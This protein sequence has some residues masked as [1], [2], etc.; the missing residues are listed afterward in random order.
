MSG[1]YGFVFSERHNDVVDGAVSADEEIFTG[2]NFGTAIVRELTQNSLDA[3]DHNVEGPVVIRIQL[4]NVPV[5]EIPDV[6]TLRTHLEASALAVEGSNDV[7]NRLGRAVDAL[8]QDTIPVLRIGDHNTYGLTGDEDDQ[9]RKP[10]LLALTRGNGVSQKAGGTGGSFGIGAKS[11]S[12][13][14]SIRTVFW[15]TRSA[16]HT[17]TVVAGRAI[18]AGHT[19]PGESA[20]LAPDGFFRRKNAKKFTY[21]RS[22][23][24]VLGFEPRAENGTDTYIL[25]YRGI[26]EEGILN[27]MRRAF[28]SQFML[29]IHSGRLLIE[30]STENGN[31]RLDEESL[32]HFIRN[33]R[34]ESADAT[35]AYYEAILTEPKTI[36]VDGLGK[37]R[38]FLSMDESL[39]ETYKPM[40]MRAPLMRIF[41]YT[42]MHRMSVNFAAVVVCDS[43]EGNRFLR[44][45]EPVAHDKWD[46]QR[47]EN[48][49]R[50]KRVLDALYK[51]V[52]QVIRDEI[53]ENLG[54]E[55][56]IKGLAALLPSNIDEGLRPA[57]KTKVTSSRNQSDSKGVNIENEIVEGKKLDEELSPKRSQEPKTYVTVSGIAGLGDQEG[58]KG[59]DTGGKK[60]RKSAGQG[61][62]TTGVRGDGNTVI[63]GDEVRFR[64]TFVKPGLLQMTIFPVDGEAL[65]G[66]IE[67]AA[68]ADDGQPEK[69]YSLG[70]TRAYIEDGLD[71]RMLEMDG[72]ILRG[73]HIPTDGL[74]VK[75]EFDRARRFKLG[76]L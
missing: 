48:P 27:E 63:Q 51:D 73:V 49:S 44:A 68:V 76:V 55:V 74:T 21:Q 20:I 35:R 31:W 70:I 75:L 23:E 56:N 13:A 61:F 10:P 71:R 46:S 18:L 15:T 16:D 52:R 47:G 22:N 45:L 69:D 7:S 34:D 3:K 26:N 24:G 43:D 40:F 32:A 25:G 4:K 17:D 58:R 30:A 8:A 14:S 42:R 62:D 2:T 39:S 72:N 5:S 59:R 50:A 33:D 29:A 37:V 60:K 36:N 28:A 12:G 41:V 1:D 6:D 19:L 66:S 9:G 57:T 38:I 53:K 64:P 54:E 11:A 65:E 67:F